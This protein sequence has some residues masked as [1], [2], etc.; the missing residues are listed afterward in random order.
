MWCVVLETLLTNEVFSQPE[1]KTANRV[2]PLWMDLH[3]DSDQI[4][5]FTLTTSN[6]GGSVVN[7]CLTILNILAGD[8]R[9]NEN[10]WSRNEINYTE[11]LTFIYDPNNM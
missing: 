1:I 4:F 2:T 3:A 6:A 11:T 8:Q 9:D 5:D 10:I 7:K